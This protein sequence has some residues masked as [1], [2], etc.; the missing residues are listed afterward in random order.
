MSD[1]IFQKKKYEPGKETSLIGSGPPYIY[2]EGFLPQ[3]VSQI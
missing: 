1:V 2:F 3:A